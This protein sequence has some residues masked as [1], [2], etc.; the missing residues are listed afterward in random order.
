MLQ[1]PLG[2]KLASVMYIKTLCPSPQNSRSSHSKKLRPHNL[3][4]STQPSRDT[5][6]PT[7]HRPAHRAHPR[8]T[9]LPTP[10]PSGKRPSRDTLRPTPPPPFAPRCLPPTCTLPL[11]PHRPSHQGAYPPPAPSRLSP[12]NLAAYPPPLRETTK[13]KYPAAYPRPGVSWEID[14]V[15]TPCRL[16][17]TPG[18][19]RRRRTPAP[20]KSPVRRAAG[21]ALAGKSRRRRVYPQ[22][23]V[24][25]RLLY[26]LQDP[27]AHL[28]RLQRI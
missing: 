24:T 8:S 19:P 25:T 27:F 6:R 2:P 17:P 18:R 13:S 7:P 26:C 4:L 21:R 15:G 1:G 12:T 22:Q 9:L 28:S 16:P 11:T 3:S 20:V 23:I 10:H 5:L 14:Q